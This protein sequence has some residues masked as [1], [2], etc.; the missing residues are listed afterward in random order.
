MKRPSIRYGLMASAAIL[1]LAA[2]VSGVPAQAGTTSNGV[3]INALSG[4]SSFTPIRPPAVPLV[5]R[6]PYNN[7]WFETP[8]GQAAHT[9]PTHWNGNVKAITGVA[10][11]DNKPYLFIG[12][13][14][15]AGLGTMTQS[16]LTTTATQSKF[17]FQAGGVS[18]TV[19]FLSPVEANDLKRLSMPLSDIL[20]R[21]QSS[22][23]ITHTV[24]VY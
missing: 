17:I 19:D 14:N 22:D 6:A 15:T 24:S 23:G 9:W 10:M 3:K 7:V 5:T 20:T 2:I 13:P 18:L 8:T 12:A 11:I 21:A 16:S 1:S 4:T